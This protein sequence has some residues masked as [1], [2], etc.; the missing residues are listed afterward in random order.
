MPL[1]AAFG[2]IVAGPEGVTCWELSFGEFGGWGDQ[3]ELYDARDRDARDHAAARPA[4]SISG[5]G[6]DDPRGDVGAE[7]PTP[8][9][10]GLEETFTAMDD[11]EW[12]EV[13]RQRNADGAVAVVREKW[14]IAEPDFMSAYIEYGP[15]H[16][17]PSP[18][19]LRSSSGLGDRRRRVV[20]RSLVPGRNPHRAA[21]RRR[22]RADHR[23][24]EGTLFLELTEWRLP[25]LGRPARAV[26][27]GDRGPRRHAACPTRPSNSASGSRTRAATGRPRRPEEGS[28]LSSQ[29]AQCQRRVGPG[30]Q[31]QMGVRGQV[32]DQVANPV[33]NMACLDHVADTTVSRDWVDR[34]SP[35]QSGSRDRSLPGAGNV[36]LGLQQW[37]GHARLA[38]STLRFILP[39]HL[40]HTRITHLVFMLLRAYV[41]GVSRAR[42]CLDLR[43]FAA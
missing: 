10:E 32:V 29:A 37:A 21:L 41:D 26:R 2:P 7:R 27:T 24:R 17:H 34:L 8:K 19:P 3:P 14:P 33:V 25:L 39:G 42:A 1:G 6:F 11:I 5:T 15:G 38:S 13:K 43:S 12:T 36:K 4:A 22:L 23:R 40:A 28:T 9:V 18:R 16:D 30:R 31:H 35:R 20:R